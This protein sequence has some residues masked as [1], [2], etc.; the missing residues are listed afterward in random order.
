LPAYALAEEQLQCRDV[1]GVS[2]V[3]SEKRADA[4]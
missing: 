2:C 3:D 1:Y 4:N